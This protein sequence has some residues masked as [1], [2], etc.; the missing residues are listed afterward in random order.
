MN[1]I[2]S[3]NESQLCKPRAR[4]YFCEIP[5]Q[6]SLFNISTKNFNLEYK[7]TFP[8]SSSLNF[9]EFLENELISKKFVN[10]PFSILS[11]FL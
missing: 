7:I 11:I 5:C 4:S 10:I 3:P 8:A 9:E 1:S 6:S 2:F